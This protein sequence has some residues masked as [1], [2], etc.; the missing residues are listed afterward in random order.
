[1]AHETLEF[2]EFARRYCERHENTPMG[3]A[4][5]F[6]RQ[7]ELYRPD[8]WM[9]LECQDFSSS[10]LGHYVI[11]PYGGQATF[12]T[13]PD[14]PISP[15]GLASDMSVVVAVLPANALPGESK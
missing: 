9:L 14:R 5:I 1:M 15:R 2:A 7:V 4:E 12:K 13:I 11:L 8:G 10:R 3:L 6:H